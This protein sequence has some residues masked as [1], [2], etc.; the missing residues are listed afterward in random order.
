MLT[1]V[2]VITTT[3]VFLLLV[4][5]A[6]TTATTIPD[7]TTGTTATTMVT[8]DDTT[9]DA[10]TQVMETTVG[11]TTG[12]NEATTQI[13]TTSIIT[14][15]TNSMN[16]T[17]YLG[18]NNQTVDILLEAVLNNSNAFSMTKIQSFVSGSGG[19]ILLQSALIPNQLGSYAAR[20]NAPEER[21]ALFYSTLLNIHLSENN[22]TFLTNMSDELARTGTLSGDK[23]L[24][25]PEDPQLLA[26]V[27]SSNT[28]VSCTP[29]VVAPTLNI[30]LIVGVTIGG[31]FILLLVGALV[32]YC[33]SK[34]KSA[35]RVTPDH[36]GS[37]EMSS[38]APYVRNP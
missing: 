6:T 5:Q 3:V 2:N 19:K 10:T 30:G 16:I 26:L 8:M 29:T 38:S 20:L 18:T 1:N 24:P 21:K 32:C 7:D 36:R 23:F 34:S 25:D 28:A 33:C 27:C 13:A 15:I 11:P 4:G 22:A 9:P 37:M 35:T 17:T 31:A 12:P 14:I